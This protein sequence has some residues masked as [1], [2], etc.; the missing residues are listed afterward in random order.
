MSNTPGP[1]ELRL[2]DEC[3]LGGH[4][5]DNAPEAQVFS[6]RQRITLRCRIDLYSALR[7]EKVYVTYLDTAGEKWVPLDELRVYN[8]QDFRV[9]P[10]PGG[11][12]E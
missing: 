6:R 8:P 11:I 1:I 3:L 7:G 5:V 2:R 4:I 9:V 10:P 12:R